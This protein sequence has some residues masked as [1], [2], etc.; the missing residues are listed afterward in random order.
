MR[1][2]E[3]GLYQYADSTYPELLKTIM[4]KKQ[5]DDPLKADMTKLL[6]EFKERF[7]GD[8]QAVAVAKA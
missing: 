4:E 2:F 3:E 7:V 5:L 1:E 6:K 8:R